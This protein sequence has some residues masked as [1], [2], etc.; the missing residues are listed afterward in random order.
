MT[1]A[2]GSEADAADLRTL[3]LELLQGIDGD[4]LATELPMPAA[5]RRAFEAAA[6]ALEEMDEPEADTVSSLLP[7]DGDEATVLARAALLYV[8]GELHLYV[9]GELHLA[10]VIAR[11]AAVPH[12]DWRRQ[13]GRLGECPLVART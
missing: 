6:V 3:A 4:W 9:A 11:Y 2:C 13:S 10:Y 1:L 12:R 5:R 8:A 7:A